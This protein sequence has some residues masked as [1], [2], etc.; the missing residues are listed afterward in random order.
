M[1]E[2]LVELADTTAIEFDL[3][4]FLRTLAN[5]CVRLL[6]VDAAGTLINDHGVAASSEP[7]AL[8]ESAALRNNEG[9]G[10]ECGRDGRP[11][12]VPDLAAAA[13]RWPRFTAEARDAGFSATHTIPLRRRAEVIGALTL[14]RADPGAVP[15]SDLRSATAMADVAT[16]G[17]LAAKAV[18][19]QRDLVAQLQYALDSRVIIEQAKGVL[20]ERLGLSM[21]AAF[22]ALRAYARSHNTKVSVLATSIV[23]GGFDTS[24]LVR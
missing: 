17:I 15:A 12:A 4:A 21:S 19:A 1:A 8:I 23:D 16:I 7:V 9:P 14:F 24:R 10:P 3:D 18:R 22:S 2:T 20:A 6:A 11:V 13:D 5:H